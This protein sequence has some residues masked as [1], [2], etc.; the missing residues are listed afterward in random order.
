MVNNSLKVAVLLACYLAAGITTLQ[1]SDLSATL[2]AALLCFVAYLI[3]LWSVRV[4]AS[5]DQEVSLWPPFL[6]AFFLY[7]NTYPFILQSGIDLVYP[8]LETSEEFTAIAQAQATVALVIMCMLATLDAWR[9]TNHATSSAKGVR[10][11]A[12]A[13]SR[14]IIGGN[15]LLMLTSLGYF[16]TIAG[17]ISAEAGRL[18]VA[19]SFNLY[20][21][22][23]LG[24]MHLLFYFA[25]ILQAARSPNHRGVRTRLIV[26]AM[27]LA[28]Y[29]AMDSAVG[30]R[31][32]IAAALLGTIYGALRFGVPRLRTITM[33]IP[34]AMVAMSVRAIF[35]DKFSGEADGFASIALQLGGEFVFTFLTFPTTIASE[36][37]FYE[38]SVNSYLM[39]GLQF[40]PR[41]LWD[42]KPF[43]LA[44]SLSNYLY[45]GQEGFS[46]VPMAEAWCTFG[47]AA[48]F[49]FPLV[50]G[51]MLGL[52]LRI[53][54][55]RPLVGFIVYAHALE[56]NRGEV[57]YLVLQV[58]TLYA[59]YAIGG[60]LAT[61]L[62]PSHPHAA[63]ANQC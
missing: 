21:W 6:I 40:V 27:L 44:Q 24:W 26:A 19:Q 2:L 30:G 36:C 47:N 43:S 23:F 56:L 9:G 16:S 31:K 32:I 60:R 61:A 52:L 1:A 17:D 45:D 15:A 53:A 3:S 11:L 10:C 7:N 58:V 13:P 28:L 62:A 29:C 63:P 38:S 4:S 57:S 34:V 48:G 8:G 39:T 42:D 37:S 14:W 35:Y 50:A 33:A 22:V 59:I 41:I 54:R 51:L 25:A 18:G 12:V 20:Q 55:R 46:I 49:A 5:R